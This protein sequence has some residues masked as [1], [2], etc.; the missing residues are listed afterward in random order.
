MNK[1]LR[2]SFKWWDENHS[3]GTRGYWRT[4]SPEK[5]GKVRFR[6]SRKQELV[7]TMTKRQRRKAGN[8]L[9]SLQ[10]RMARKREDCIRE[11]KAKLREMRQ[12]HSIYTFPDI[13][14]HVSLMRDGGSTYERF[15]ELCATKEGRD[16]ILCAGDNLQP[17][18]FFE[19][20]EELDTSDI[21]FF[22][23]S[24]WRARPYV[25]FKDKFEHAEFLLTHP[26][27][28]VE[29]PDVWDN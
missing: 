6:V 13:G 1:Q 5:L 10:S 18:I 25:A 16:R 9:S 23:F 15:H 12:T 4:V 29:V 22:T 14:L 3:F 19:S 26:I 2:E 27:E 8:W 24:L 21:A 28:L 7:I 17:K 20:D 11:N